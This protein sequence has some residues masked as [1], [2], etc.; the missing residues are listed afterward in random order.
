IDLTGQVVRDS[1]GHHFYGGVGSMQDFIRGA[2]G[3]KDGQPM[4]VLTSRSDDGKRPRIVAELEPGSGVSTGRSDIHHVV[5]EYGVAS[6]F[7][8]SIRERVARLVE[9]AHPD[10][11]EELLKGARNRGWLPKFFTMSGGAR[12]GVESKVFD[13]TCGR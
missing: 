10:D 3:S 5:T 12:G 4:I 11:R 2:G 13:F 6:I 8:R 7:G 9:I 1:S